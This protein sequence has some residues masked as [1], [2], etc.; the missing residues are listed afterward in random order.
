MATQELPPQGNHYGNSYCGT[1]LGLQAFWACPL[2]LPE[3]GWLIW[4]SEKR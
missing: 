2:G 1:A 3:G 4:A